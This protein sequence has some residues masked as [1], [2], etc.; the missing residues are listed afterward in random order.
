MAKPIFTY[1]LERDVRV[2]VAHVRPDL[3]EQSLRLLDDTDPIIEGSI[4]KLSGVK[5]LQR[6]SKGFHDEQ[7][8]NAHL[9]GLGGLVSDLSKTADRCLVPIPGES[10]LGVWVGTSAQEYFNTDGPKTDK[11]LPSMVLAMAEVYGLYS[12]EEPTE[13]ILAENS[14]GFPDDDSGYLSFKSYGYEAELFHGHDALTDWRFP[15]F[16]LPGDPGINV[17]W[18]TRERIDLAQEGCLYRAVSYNIDHTSQTLALTLGVGRLA[19]FASQA[20]KD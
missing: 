8:A 9:R 3:L 11:A 18:G 2:D 10:H 19:Y 12:N 14:Y 16:K 1:D 20:S 7:L 17:P 4:L 6:D 13:E 5:L 15:G